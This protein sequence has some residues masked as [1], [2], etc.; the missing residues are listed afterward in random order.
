M[1]P[2]DEVGAV[3]GS[4]NDQGE[5]ARRTVQPL[6]GAGGRGS[7][8]PPKGRSVRENQARPL[9]LAAGPLVLTEASAIPLRQALAQAL[10][11]Q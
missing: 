4:A 11:S 1:R 10:T 5:R 9:V 6:A 7:T 8:C 3:Q 2:E